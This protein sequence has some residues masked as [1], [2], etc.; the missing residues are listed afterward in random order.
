MQE[1]LQL[2]GLH[3]RLLPQLAQP[4]LMPALQSDN[5][6]LPLLSV[7]IL[8]CRQQPRAGLLSVPA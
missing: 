2:R 7:D 1:Q 3:P 8:P 6:G 4:Q 5:S